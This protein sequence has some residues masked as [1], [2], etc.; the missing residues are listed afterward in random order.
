MPPKA[1]RSARTIDALLNDL[2]DAACIAAIFGAHPSTHEKCARE[3]ATARARV[4]R[5]IAT[6]ERRIEQARADKRRILFRR[7]KAA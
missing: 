6:L 7:G 3:L 1:S 4:E 2:I 5:Y